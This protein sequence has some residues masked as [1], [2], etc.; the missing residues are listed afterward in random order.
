[1]ATILDRGYVWKKG[2]ALVPSFTAFA[3]IRLLEEHFAALIDYD[4]TANM[5]TVL[6]LVASGDVHRVRQPEAFWRGGTSVN[7]AFP[8]VKALTE[9][10]GSID[11]RGNATFAIKGSDAHLRVGRYGARLPY[12][13]PSAYHRLS[14]VRLTCKRK[15]IGLIF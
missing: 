2:S 13:S 4:F 15:P 1:M 6:A 14:H 10:L 12:L 3:V 8:G 5:E 7:G 11:A 9:D